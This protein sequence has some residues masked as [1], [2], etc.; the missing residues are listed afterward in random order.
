LEFRLLG[1]LE[2][3]NDGDRVEVTGAK[4]RALLVALLLRAN[5]PVSTDRL[6][7]DLWGERPPPTAAKTLQVYVSQLRK[8]FDSNGG[9]QVLVTRPPGY[10]VVVDAD[11]L[12]VHRFERLVERART[13]GGAGN[14]VRAA[15]LLREALSLW[16]GPALADL[17][18]EPFVQPEL[19]RLEE[20]RQVA[21]E[22]RIEAD[23]ALGRHTELV[24]ELEALVAE[25]PLRERL[26]AQLMLALYRSGRQAEA[27]D[28]Y[29]RAR[30]ALVEQ[31]GID[32]GPSLQEL[33][34]AILRQD[35]S[36]APPPPPAERVPAPTIEEAEE[37]T[38]G[39]EPAAKKPWSRRRKALVAVGAMLV[40]GAATAGGVQL[41]RGGSTPV[42]VVAGDALAVVDPATSALSDVVAVPSSPERIAVA[43]GRL[44]V[45]GR[46]TVTAIDL[47]TREIT[48]VLVP[49]AAATD[50]AAGEGSLWLLDGERGA[51]VEIDPA[52]QEV[53]R[54]IRLAAPA[55][56]AQGFGPTP[57]AVAAGEGGVWVVDGSETLLRLNPE[58]G[59]VVAELELG[60]PLNGV[61]AGLGSVWAVSGPEATVIEVDPRAGRIVAEIEL[62]ALPDSASPF[63]I[64]VDVGEGAVWALNGNTATVTK[65]DPT[66]R[67]V[68]AT[69]PIGVGRNPTALAVADGAV[70]V[71]NAADGTLARVDV[72][73]QDVR[74]VLVGSRPADVAVGDGG[75]WV[76]AQAGLGTPPVSPQGDIIEA[77][78]LDGALPLS[79]CSPVYT[80][81]G[82]EPEYLVVSDL[83]LQGSPSALTAPMVAAIK[84]VLAEYGFEAGGLALGYQSCEGAAAE[85][86]MAS[87]ERCEANARAY[88]EH[89]RVVA[90]I[91]PFF[92][93][94]AV[95]QLPLANA[96]ADGPL[97]FVGPAL[98]YVGLTHEGPGVAAGE[99]ERYYPTGTRSLVR[100]VAPDDYQGAAIALAAQQAAATR[101]FVLVGDPTY[102]AGIAASV[103]RAAARLGIDVVGRGEWDPDA[104][105][106]AD[107]AELVAGS[108]TDGVFLAGYRETDLVRDLRA[109]LSPDVRIFAPDGFTA[110]AELI[111]GAGAA[112][113][114]M[115]VSVPGV[116]PERLTGAGK[117]FVER[118]GSIVGGPV[119]PFAVTA[120]AATEVVL[121]AIA[122]SDGSRESVTASLLETR[123]EDGILGV[124]AFD[125]NG[126]IASKA[127]T[128]Y[129]VRD[130]SPRVFDVIAPPEELVAP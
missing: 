14:P 19:A 97:A 22:E 68:E 86:G 123:I 40:A 60:R 99:V 17:A 126:D 129:E 128:I 69:I 124:T 80:L 56:P 20:L 28:A 121:D 3:V 92:S 44:W 114:G 130:G 94:C 37:G 8:L 102:G 118:F 21:L 7:D 72:A 26:W 96:A 79:L 84:F 53:V 63:P 11:Q 87:P 109:A 57:A 101:L 100:M 113:D 33:E 46:E 98:T 32:P 23:L 71:A 2:I 127:V 15:S 125:R 18:Y 25:H 16:R 70:W 51:V 78:T 48:D 104:T 75:V 35:P 6:I 106:F 50:L 13:A 74:S 55:L 47:E 107:V 81:R 89:P 61:A 119:E 103:E 117:E 42:A 10:A 31:L 120:A 64:A 34:Q 58:T 93:G 62:V 54:T 83:P 88:V 91:G 59:A 39:A 95:V 110:F 66:L 30:Y 4:R 1:P 27:L 43:E 49:G 116:P 29:R 45:A 65:I 90:V 112:A 82:Q 67:G 77:F 105:D 41:A 122:R 52:Y 115:L 12:D 108:G 76:A 36:L 38:I 9:R 73:T 111:G 24:G 5:E 85:T